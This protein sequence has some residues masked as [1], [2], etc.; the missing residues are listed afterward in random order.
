M[1]QVLLVASDSDIRETITCVL[2][3]GGHAVTSTSEVALARSL[4]YVSHHPLVVLLCPGVDASHA[5]SLLAE[6]AAAVN[7]RLARHRYLLLSTLPCQLAA[8]RDRLAAWRVP[9]IAMPFD[10]DDLLAAVEQGDRRI[11]SRAI[12][13]SA[14]GMVGIHSAAAATGAP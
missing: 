2:E 14:L 8:A 6:T 9:V 7:P 13:A 5:L 11:D 3:E 1:A 10:I 12:E 4:L